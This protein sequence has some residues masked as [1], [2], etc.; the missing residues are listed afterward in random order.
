MDRLGCL[1]WAQLSDH[2]SILQQPRLLAILGEL[3]TFTG[4]FVIHVE[5]QL[6]VAG[7]I[8]VLALA[9]PLAVLPLAVVDIAVGKGVLPLA[10]FLGVLVLADVDGAVG[11][12]DFGPAVDLSV[13][14]GRRLFTAIHGLVALGAHLQLRLDAVPPLLF[15]LV[16]SRFHVLLGQS[17]AANESSGVP[18]LK[19]PD[20][21]AWHLK[22][23]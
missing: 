12:D 11:K 10:V 7:G 19:G 1:T 8:G 3:H 20:C 9:V 23:A 15:G 18:S 21:D 2:L 4:V 14:V 5:T 6:E 13:G 22:P 17:A 16:Q